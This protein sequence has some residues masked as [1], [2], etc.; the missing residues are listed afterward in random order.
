MGVTRRTAGDLREAAL[1][2]DRDGWRLAEPGEIPP[3][4]WIAEHDADIDELPARPGRRVHWNRV[5]SVARLLAEGRGDREV[6][7]I[8]GIHPG[9]VARDKRRVG[10]SR[11]KSKGVPYTLTRKAMTA[12][13]DGERTHR[14]G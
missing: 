11:P 5:R 7:E 6:A 1:I 9:Q 14:A 13:D 8:L 3:N 10:L 2:F 4:W 12:L